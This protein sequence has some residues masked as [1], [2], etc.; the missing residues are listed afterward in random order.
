MESHLQKRLMVFCESF[1]FFFFFAVLGLHC[2]EGFSL[3]VVSRSYSLV[4]KRL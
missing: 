4:M 3:L 2:Y 1:A